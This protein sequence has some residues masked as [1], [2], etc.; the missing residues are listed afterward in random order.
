MTAINK[1]FEVDAEEE[2][3]IF[4]G[5]EETISIKVRNKNKLK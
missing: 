2:L 1:T 5:D 3:R 4:L